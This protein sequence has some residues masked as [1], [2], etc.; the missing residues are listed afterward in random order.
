MT[1]KLNINRM[2]SVVFLPLNLEEP[3]DFVK[4]LLVATSIHSRVGSEEMVRTIG[5]PEY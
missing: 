3:S 5:I 1:L 2:L 4:L